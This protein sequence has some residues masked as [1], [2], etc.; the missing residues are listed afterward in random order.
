MKS[1]QYHNAVFAAVRSQL[2]REMSVMMGSKAPLVYGRSAFT[3]GCLCGP[4]GPASTIK[5][6]WGHK[7]LLRPKLEIKAVIIAEE[8]YQPVQL[9]FKLEHLPP[10][11]LLSSGYA[12]MTR[13]E[14]AGRRRYTRP[15]RQRFGPRERKE[16]QS[17]W[18][19]ST[20]SRE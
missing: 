14:G 4:D 9:G 12:G 3:L 20:I 18:R 16:R 8:L 11:A 1:A 13:A 2:E 17:V 19:S 7:L 10:A 5:S 6:H 15:R